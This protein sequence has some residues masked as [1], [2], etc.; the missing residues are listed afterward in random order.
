MKKGKIKMVGKALKVYAAEKGL[1][2]SNGVVY[3]IYRGFMLSMHEGSGWKSAAFAVR[4]ADEVSLQAAVGF[5][6][7]KAV[8]KQ[9]RIIGCDAAASGLSVTFSDNP[10]TMKR[11]REFIDVF[12]DKLVALGGVG[13]T[14]CSSCGM[15]L[16]AGMG[17][18]ALMNGIVFYMHE[19]C[20]ERDTA[21]LM[22]SKEETS[23]NGSVASGILGALLG[24]LLGAIPWAIAYYYGW[25]VALLGLV[26]GIAAKKGYEL[27]HGKSNKAKGVVIIL[28][29]VLG[30][31]LGEAGAIIYAIYDMWLADPEISALGVTVL[32]AAFTF[33]HTLFTDSTLIGDMALDIVMGLFFAGLGI[34]QTV[35]QVFRATDEKTNM[36][37]RLQ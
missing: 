16:D 26:I 24:A 14:H 37:I 3:G 34:Y 5:L 31:F 1:A 13:V 20:L 21:S 30:V 10:G 32:D 4:F 35:L 28:A 36:L 17:V 18:P 9:Y 2:V 15:P 6:N 19:G 23:K 12:C 7:D 11:I 33:F 8:K 29:T 27:F 22:R 25:F